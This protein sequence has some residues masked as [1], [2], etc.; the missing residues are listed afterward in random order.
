MEYL[1]FPA[2]IGAPAPVGPSINCA[3]L[4]N[5]LGKKLKEESLRTGLLPAVAVNV[6]ALLAYFQLL[7]LSVELNVVAAS[8]LSHSVRPV[9]NPPGACAIVF[10]NK[11]LQKDTM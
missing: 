7:R 9:L 6:L 5:T 11:K 4:N 2:V 1:R 3:P 8:A 10:K